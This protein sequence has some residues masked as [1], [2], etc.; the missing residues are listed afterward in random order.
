MI[1]AL[2]ALAWLRWRL[3]LNGFR[4]SR[5]DSL[6]R[7]SRLAAVAVPAFLAVLA[8]PTVLTLAAA[9]FAGGFL[10]ARSDTAR[11]VLGIV[12]RALLAVLTFAVLIGPLVRSIQGATL[13]LARLVL[14]PIPRRVLHLAELGA[15]L[16]DPWILAV[17]PSLAAL[18]AGLLLSGS[19]AAGAAVLA[20]GVTL[21]LVLAALASASS[22]VIALLLRNRRRGEWVTLLF[23][24]VLSVA[25]FLPM[26]LSPPSR[27]RN[28]GE[29]VER[30]PRGEADARPRLEL[31][32]WTRGAP[33]ELYAAALER[34]LAGEAA[35]AVVPV[36]GLAGSA[37][38]LYLV[39]WMAYRR[40]LETPAGGGGKRHAERRNLFLARVPGLSPGVS[41]VALAEV[42][43][44]LRTVRGKSAVFFTPVALGVL[45]FMGAR[46][47][48][49]DPEGSGLPTLGGAL[50]PWATALFSVI[51]LHPFLLN[52]FATDRSG[53]SL[54]FL[55]PLSDRDLVRGKAAGLT[56]LWGLTFA[57]CAGV[58]IAL[59][60]RAHPAYWLSAAIGAAS[61]LALL[62][63][64]A[65]AF[66]ALFPK[67]ADLGRIGRS[68]NPHPTASLV[69]GLLSL[70]LGL[71]PA[72]LAALGLAA[73]KSP[74]LAL[75]L[76]SAW[77][78]I[79]LAAGHALL[80]PASRVVTR[81]RENLALVAEGR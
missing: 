80:G 67:A 66:S 61:I 76:V 17:L 41:A 43:L 51:A 2:R 60:P 70:A 1:R 75:L 28:P 69:G 18:P 38:V 26:L 29:R 12:P 37:A 71:P 65:A 36:A 33:S 54:Q 48:R 4:K 22:F 39:S 19:L 34:S 27:H 15:G 14:L 35:G 13:G 32:A 63:P 49:V 8:I 58:G 74:T 7:A 72:G 64:A 16:A 73:F 68:G 6:E 56:L 53:L 62:M 81:R 47:G 59:G 25:G 11:V 78:V 3:L 10:A 77:A 50:L 40:L 79:A 24:A 20:A 30:A 52:Q 44:V 5:R 55:S 23:V 9:A 46:G 45:A 21:A 31:P 57:L 42:R